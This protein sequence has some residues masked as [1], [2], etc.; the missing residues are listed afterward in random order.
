[1]VL[2]HVFSGEE[3]MA[4]SLKCLAYKLTQFEPQHPH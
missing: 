3:E 2:K 1:M 4:H